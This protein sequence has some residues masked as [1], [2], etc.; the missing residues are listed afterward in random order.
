MVKNGNDD[1][2]LHLATTFAM[3]K[4][5]LRDR[6][7]F[8][9]KNNDCETPM[10]KAKADNKCT[11]YQYFRMKKEEMDRSP[12]PTRRNIR[13]WRE[14]GQKVLVVQCSQ[15]T[16][17]T[18]TEPLANELVIHSPTLA[19]NEQEESRPQ[20]QVESATPLESFMRAILSDG[21]HE[22]ED[23]EQNDQ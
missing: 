1:T 13:Q 17:E 5:L 16:C 7:Y 14:F 4:L 22:P 9:E 19:T 8:Y 11:I 21:D 18:C 3:V 10:E 6:N 12:K 23:G 15:T 20:T 2:P